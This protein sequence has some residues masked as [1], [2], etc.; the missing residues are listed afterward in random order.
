MSEAE[1]IAQ[2]RRG[3]DEAWVSLVR[4]HQ[5][6][7][8]R[9]AYLLLDDADDAA[10][11]AQEVFVRAWR[12]RHRLDVD[13]PLRPW[14]LQITRN[15]CF[16]W[17]RSARRYL[18]LLGRWGLTQPLMVDPEEQFTQAWQA[19]ALWQAVRQLRPADQEMIY[20]RCFLDLSVE[21]TA[22]V[23]AAPS[24][25]VKSRLSRALARLRAL[26]ERDL[27]DLGRGER[28]GVAE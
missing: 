25:T 4:H 20:L 16:N 14:L 8:F 27:P 13:R 19:T 28:K 10:D 11:V 26:I 7:V 5:D 18:A 15:Q 2:A 22:A 1:Q 3:D 23:V 17:R 12:A 24:G 9:L 6:A 21:E